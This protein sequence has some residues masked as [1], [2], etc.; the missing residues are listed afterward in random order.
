MSLG[1]ELGCGFIDP[2]SQLN[3]FITNN[4]IVYSN[5]FCYTS[6]KDVNR[7]SSISL[8]PNPVI[9]QL[10][11]MG[12]TASIASLQISDLSGRILKNKVLQDDTTINVETIPLG[13]YFCKIMF[14]D[15]QVQVLKF[16]KILEKKKQI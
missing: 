5:G 11:I 7:Q 15:G 12:N 9:D 16:I 1:L 6:V 8:L 4:K 10:Q 2:E 3:C 13:I 14:L